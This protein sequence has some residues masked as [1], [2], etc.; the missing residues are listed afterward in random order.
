MKL[1]YITFRSITPAQ[2]GEHLLR[3]GGVECYM[4]RTPAWMEE[5]GCGYCLRLHQKNA[6][7]G[8]RL[9]RENGVVFRKVYLQQED[10]SFEE[11][12]L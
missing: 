6:A 7:R 2:R 10:H 9:L 11:I 3:R 8:V 1:C 12:V 4:N 5:Q